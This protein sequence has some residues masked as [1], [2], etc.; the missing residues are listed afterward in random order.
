MAWIYLAELEG[1]ASPLNLGSE[2]SPTVSVTD[3]PKPFCFQEWPREC[4]IR[5]Q[6]G[7]TCEALREKCSR[8]S[9]SLAEDFPARTL[10]RRELAE[11]WKASEVVYSL[12]SFDSLANFDPASF[13]WRTSQLSLFG[14]LTAFSW[15]SLR[16]GSIVGGR[17][18][19]PQRL[20][21]FTAES[22]GGYLDT[23]TVS[24]A[25]YRTQKMPTPTA[26]RYGSNVSSSSG[27]TVRL[28]LDG[29]ALR[30][31]L[32][33]HPKGSLNPEWEEQAMG[34]QIGWTGLPAWAIAWFR[35]RRGKRLSV[36]LENREHA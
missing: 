30:G 8:Q 17:L 23:P 2:R 28:S 13:S 35:P 7:M 31:I 22:D 11:A 16:W 6:F 4:S 36:S 3:M 5:P 19:Q 20:E 34:F 14:G 26:N 18:Y 1:S 24:R 27:A 25:T 10:V 21:P 32:P 9:T 33:G 29:M 12:K 15:N